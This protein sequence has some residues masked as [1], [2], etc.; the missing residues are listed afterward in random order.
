MSPI[1]WESPLS[2]KYGASENMCGIHIFYDFD[3]EEVFHHGKA[4][5]R[6][7]KCLANLV[8]SSCPSDKKPALLLTRNKYAKQG[9]VQGQGYCVTVVNID[10][11]L[12]NASGDAATT[13]FAMLIKGSDVISAANIDWSMLSESDIKTLFSKHIN[14]E[15]L[16]AWKNADPQR[17][18]ILISLLNESK[19]DPKVLVAGRE[20]EFAA[21]LP[22]VFGKHFW[23]VLGQVGAELPDVLAHKRLWSIRNAQVEDFRTHLQKSDWLETDWQKFFEKNKWIF[24]YG[25]SYQFLHILECRPSFGGKDLTGTGSLEGDFLLATSAQIKFTV[26]VE[27]K[28]PNSNLV[29]DKKYRNRTYE[30]GEDLVGGVAQLQQQCWRWAIEGSRTDENRDLLEDQDI[31]T[32]HPKGILVIGNTNDLKSNRDKM[33]IFES[34]RRNL[35]NPEVITF[36]ELLSRAE[37]AVQSYAED[38]RGKEKDHQLEHSLSFVYASKATKINALEQGYLTL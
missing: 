1:P 36:D 26:L 15:L 7:G 13:Y 32:H 3:W 38:A 25:L 27:I 22:E 11:Y 28:R 29:S 12:E 9:K 19:I 37:N 20:N 2:F 6:N 34:F 17:I 10:N 33:K 21:I 23:D 8:T 14:L 30:F 18:D 4:Q 31:Y 24:G 35:H 16:R 5:F